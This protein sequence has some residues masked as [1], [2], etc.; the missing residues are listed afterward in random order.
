MF[1]YNYECTDINCTVQSKGYVSIEIQRHS[2]E[3]QIKMWKKTHWNNKCGNSCIYSIT[4]SHDSCGVKQKQPEFGSGGRH[5]NAITFLSRIV[6]VIP[7]NNDTMSSSLKG[8]VPYLHFNKHNFGVAY[9]IR[10]LFLLH[11]AHF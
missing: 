3:I 4:K 6:S 5:G 2:I 11:I 10:D 9:K 7:K 8:A 1:I